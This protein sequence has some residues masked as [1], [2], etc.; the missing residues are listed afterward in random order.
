MKSMQNLFTKCMKLLLDLFADASSRET[1]SM[2]PPKHRQFV[3]LE[4]DRFC[5][6][7][8]LDRMVQVFARK[9]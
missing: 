6:E 4:G 8:S 2:W 3:G 1:S 5:F 7:A 9:A